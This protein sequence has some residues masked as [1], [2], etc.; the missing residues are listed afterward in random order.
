[1]THQVW[2]NDPTGQI[3]TNLQT[4]CHS[5]MRNIGKVATLQIRIFDKPWNEFLLFDIN[6]VVQRRIAFEIL[7]K[8]ISTSF[9]KSE[10]SICVTNINI[11]RQVQVKSWELIIITTL[12]YNN[13]NQPHTIPYCTWGTPINSCTCQC[14]HC[15]LHTSVQSNY[16]HPRHRCTVHQ[17]YSQRLVSSHILVT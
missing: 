15:A 16:C 2:Q 6:K 7:H 12:H 17:N 11:R 8:R 1:M 9:Y 4:S 10:E 3:W 14:D 5:F 13:S